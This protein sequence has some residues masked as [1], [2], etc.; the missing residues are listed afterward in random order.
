MTAFE[1]LFDLI[2]SF[3]SRFRL[4]V[5]FPCLLSLPIGP[6]IA[7]VSGCGFTSLVKA[8]HHCADIKAATPRTI[9]MLYE[10]INPSAKFRRL[11]RG[12]RSFF[13]LLDNLGLLL[14]SN[15]TT[16]RHHDWYQQV[17]PCCRFRTDRETEPAH[18]QHLWARTKMVGGKFRTV[19]AFLT[20][21]VHR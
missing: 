16:V 5:F 12:R 19:E 20:W 18:R 7:L 9:S 3:L 1:R 21:L 17:R 13:Q 6:I 10:S 11:Y 15:G 14:I 8:P 4:I 2:S